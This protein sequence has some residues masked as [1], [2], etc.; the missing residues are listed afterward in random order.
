MPA[1]SAN[2]TELT[3]PIAFATPNVTVPALTAKL[4]EIVLAAPKISVPAPVLLKF[5]A[6]AITPL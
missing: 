1:T 3:E 5:P 4:P 6:P 2:D